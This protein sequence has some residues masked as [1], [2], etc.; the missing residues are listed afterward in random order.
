MDSGNYFCCFVF[1]KKS[2]L[3]YTPMTFEETVNSAFAFSILNFLPDAIIWVYPVVKEGAVIDFEV[4]YANE[5]A[6]QAVN[7]PKGALTGLHIRGDGVPSMQSAEANFRH[8]LDVYQSRQVKE[9]TFFAHHSGREMETVRR[10]LEGGVLST[11]RDR[12]EQ[13]EAERKEQEKSQLLNGVVNNAPIGIVVYESICDESGKICDF[14]VKLYN[15]ILH[16]LS[17]VSE[18]E[19]QQLTFKALLQTLGSEDMLGRYIALVETGE[20]F[21]FEYFNRRVERWLN[22]S[23]VKMGNGFLIMLTDI[24]EVHEAQQ[25]IQQ[26]SEHLS[27]ILNASTSAV[28]TMEA[29]RDAQ[30]EIVDLRYKQVNQRFLKWL[31]K[32]REQVIG[33]TMLTL[34]PNTKP[35]GIFDVYRQV[36]E[37]GKPQQL[38]THY[39]DDNIE[40][41]FD[42]SVARL[43]DH[44]AVGTFYDITPRR[45][46]V[47]LIEEQKNLL[48]NILTNSSN[49]I[50]VSQMIRDENNRVIDARTILANEAAIRN[51]GL[52]REVY[53]SKTAIEID[54]NILDSPYYQMCLQTLE[55]GEPFITQYLLEVSGRWLELSVSRM[56]RDHLIHIF[57]DITAIKESQLQQEKLVEELKRSNSYLEDFAH[58]ASHDMKEPLRKIR[59]FIDRL[60]HSLGTRLT[61]NEQQL[62]ERVD[63]SANRMQLMVDDLLEFSYVSERPQEMES[64]ELNEIIQKVLTDFDLPI[65]EKKATITID[66]LPAIKGHQRQ[67]EQLFHNLIGNALKYSKADTPPIIKIQSRLVK[68]ADTPVSY[69]QDQP[70]QPFYQLEVS[71]NGIGFEPQYAEQIFQMFQRLHGKTE[72]AGTGVGLSIARK[73][74]DNHHGYMWANGEPGVGAHF[75]ILLPAS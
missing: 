73:V 56:D 23:I 7:H 51:I 8:F 34:F 14:Q 18:R 11:T 25:A 42:L 70:N 48:H 28:V 44:T 64:V 38:E 12:R 58:A 49:G 24:H 75:Y 55:T 67:L 19:R 39:Y 4:R 72:Y 50:S 27:D 60:K 54:P 57:T 69:L 10:P 29:V 53:L 9:Y 62:F 2:Y 15:D 71:D 32:T 31:Q 66:P 61:E 43:D 13:R 33:E 46:A 20:A 35:E 59:T 47:A 41:W 17:G 36:I 68:G 6:N 65:E 26:Q 5:A 16:Q 63:A 52:P 22:L 37:S 45:A 30:G 3:A 40:I 74:V 21:S 1:D